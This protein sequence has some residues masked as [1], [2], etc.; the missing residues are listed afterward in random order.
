MYDMIKKEVFESY[1]DVVDTLFNKCNK[2]EKL[3]NIPIRV[4]DT[5]F[6][7]YFP[8]FTTLLK[9]IQHNIEYHVTTLMLILF[10]IHEFDNFEI[11][12]CPIL[13]ALC[14]AFLFPSL[15]NGEIT[16]TIIIHV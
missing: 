14:N 15:C 6:L 2:S 10:K 9:C 4:S 3:G 8:S 11:L 1:T 16:N 5:T 13:W 7:Q 12:F